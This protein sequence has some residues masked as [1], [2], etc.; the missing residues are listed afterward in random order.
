VG[1]LERVDA[2]LDQPLLGAREEFE[3]ECVGDRGP[4]GG[5][6]RGDGR[7]LAMSA[8]VKPMKSLIS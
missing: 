7:R 1:A 2:A 6:D 5:E 3:V 8:S 4:V